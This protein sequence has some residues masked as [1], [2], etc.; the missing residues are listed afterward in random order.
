MAENE[1]RPS[2]ILDAEVGSWPEYRKYVVAQLRATSTSVDMIRESISELKIRSA[3]LDAHLS[4]VINGTIEKRLT[5]LENT[6]NWAKG[7]GSVAVLIW[8]IFL[9]FL[10]KWWHI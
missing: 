5:S 3:A 7:I 4:S 9:L 1:G 2:E 8:S 10:S 6:R